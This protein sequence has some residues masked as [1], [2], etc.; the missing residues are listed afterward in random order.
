MRAAV[1]LHYVEGMSYQEVSAATGIAAGTL[2]VLSHRARAR[3][4]S[5]LAA[6]WQPRTR[7][8]RPRM[9]ELEIHEVE[10]RVPKERPPERRFLIGMWTV[11][12]KSKSDERRLRIWIGPAEGQALAMGLTGTDVPRPQTY[13]FMLKMIEGLGGKV[14]RVEITEV[15]DD[16]F[17]ATAF[18]RSGRHTLQ[19]DA[20]PSDALNIALR[21]QAQVL[22]SEQIMERMS[23]VPGAPGLEGVES[24]N[25]PES[26]GRVSLRLFGPQTGTPMRED[27]LEWITGAEMLQELEQRQRAWVNACRSCASSA[28]NPETYGPF[29][30]GLTCANRQ[31]L[32]AES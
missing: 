30:L 14:E 4:Q 25:R 5:E 28:R 21:S 10:V 6:D 2:R 13:E 15:V 20:R 16:T 19:I 3:L 31:E 1:W 7:V 29:P 26:S 8:R 9:I 17:I 27:E 12:L 32:I 18:L 22:V 23:F 24:A 11:L